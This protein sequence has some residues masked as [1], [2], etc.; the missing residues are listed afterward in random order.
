MPYL[1]DGHNLI[2]HIPGLKLADD[3]DEIALIAILQ[4]FASQ[5]RA[6]LEV[7]FDQASTVGEGSSSHGLVRAHFIRGDSS[8]DQA[9]KRRLKRLGRNARNWTVVTS[10]REIIAEARSF[11]CQLMTSQDFSNLLQ[12]VNAG[13]GRSHEKSDQPESSAEDI[14]Y[15][16]DQ[17]GE[18]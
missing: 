14:S 13:P 15:W 8:A 2:P 3:D 6:K 7:Y 16:M 4:R 10:D 11:H 17:F 9:I 18:E 12:A 5:R 1:V